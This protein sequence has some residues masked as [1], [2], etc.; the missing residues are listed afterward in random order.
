MKIRPLIVSGTEVPLREPTPLQVHAHLDAASHYPVDVTYVLLCWIGDLGAV[1]PRNRV[2]GIEKYAARVL[3]EFPVAGA[4][5]IDII[6]AADACWADAI[7]Q[8]DI[9]PTQEAVD[10]AGESSAATGEKPSPSP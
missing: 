9:L 2:E 1:S 6:R 5:M 10:A 7:R 3:E 4:R 8:S